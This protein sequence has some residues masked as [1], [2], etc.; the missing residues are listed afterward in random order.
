MNSCEAVAKYK[1]I[2]VVITFDQFYLFAFNVGRLKNTLDSSLTCSTYSLF[3]HRCTIF[4]VFNVN[5][6]LL[7][8]YLREARTFVCKFFILF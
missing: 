6:Y 5:P 1:S 3:A 4:A 7:D 2:K 8:M